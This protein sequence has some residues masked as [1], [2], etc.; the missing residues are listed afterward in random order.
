MPTTIEVPKIVS[1]GID[2][3]RWYVII[4]VRHD[5]GP[6]AVTVVVTTDDNGL[7]SFGSIEDWLRSFGSIE[8]WSL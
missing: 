8:D 5:H 2:M 4:T 7:R 1:V 3:H 6:D